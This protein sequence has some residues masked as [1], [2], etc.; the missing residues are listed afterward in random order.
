M[1]F[2][3]T[4]SIKRKLT[5]V[6]MLTSC[7]ALLLACGAFVIYERFSF[8]DDLVSQMSALANVTGKTCQAN[9]SFDKPEQA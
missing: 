7:I 5:S 3:A 6:I 9:L 2:F 1:T 4:S 8:R